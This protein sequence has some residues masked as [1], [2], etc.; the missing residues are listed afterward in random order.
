MW[1]LTP[2]EVLL[3]S[4]ASSSI[5]FCLS[6]QAGLPECLFSAMTIRLEAIASIGWRPSL[7][8]W[9][10]LL[11]GWRPT[12]LEAI[13]SIVWRPLL[14]GWRPLLLGWRP[15][16]LGWRILLLGWRSRY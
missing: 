7:I 8:G 3:L 5:V 14:L 13:A 9:R 6:A 16:L 12:L 11:L 4:V 10:P 2:K 1:V 15:L